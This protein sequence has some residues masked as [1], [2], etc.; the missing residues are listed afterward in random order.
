MQSVFGKL[1]CLRTRAL[2]ECIISKASWEALVQVTGE[3]VS[4]LCFWQTNVTVLN[5]K[6]APLKPDLSSDVEVFCDASS[7]GYDGYLCI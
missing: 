3:A 7:E 4:E 5:I 6:D 1:E 2:H